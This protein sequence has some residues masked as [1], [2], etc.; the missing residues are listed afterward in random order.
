[1]PI[2]WDKFDDTKVVTV[3]AKPANGQWTMVRTMITGPQI[4]R[5]E[6][7]GEWRPVAGLEPCSADGFQHWAFG[8]DRLLTSKAPLGAL[9]AKI[10]SSNLTEPD[11]N[12][13]VVGSLA[14][15]VVPDKTSGPLYLTINDAP[16]CFDDNSGKMTVTIS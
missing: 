16:G 6:A 11:A 3:P 8:R 12:V 14:V 7:T 13:Q 9:I 10:G 5:L 2:D 15:I 4:I 1:M